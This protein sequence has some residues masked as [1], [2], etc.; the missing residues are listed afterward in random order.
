MRYDNGPSG[1]SVSRRV[2]LWSVALSILT[3]AVLTAA[4]V[5][6]FAI[7][8]STQVDRSAEAHSAEQERAWGHEK[9]EAPETIA[10]CAL[11]LSEIY[12][13]LQA[14][15]QEHGHAPVENGRKSFLVGQITHYLHD[16]SALICPADPTKGTHYGSEQHPSS[17][18][19]L[20]SRYWFERNGRKYLP[21]A[22]DSPVVICRHHP[23]VALVLRR[24]GVVEVVP[25]GKYKEIRVRFAE[26]HGSPA[27]A[28]RDDGHYGD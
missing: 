18:L 20:Y 23:G 21:L 28:G 1:D 15:E 13:A 12:G 11:Q 9:R 10:R 6:T 27:A 25:N 8:R 5:L 22:G 2:L 14:Y 26:E 7:P 19:Y 16:Q 4:T 24:N 17:Y 3:G